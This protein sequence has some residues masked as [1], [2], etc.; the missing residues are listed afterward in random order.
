MQSTEHTD[1]LAFP[2]D[3][4]LGQVQEGADRLHRRTVSYCRSNS[5]KARLAHYPLSVHVSQ[6][7]RARARRTPRHGCR[8]QGH[9]YLSQQAALH[10]HRRQSGGRHPGQD[11]LDWS[12]FVTGRGALPHLAVEKGPDPGLKCLAILGLA[13]PDD[14][15]QPAQIVKRTEV[16]CVAVP[17]P[18]DFPSPVCRARLRNMRQ[19]AVVAVPEAAVDEDDLA[20]APETRGP[21]SPASPVRCNLNL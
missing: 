11:V 16:R 15:H 4:G 8:A 7:H 19:P 10:A 5:S 14:Q 12:P 9:P 6:A 20:A 21:A 1:K 3:Y 17:V 18:L 2:T 13:F